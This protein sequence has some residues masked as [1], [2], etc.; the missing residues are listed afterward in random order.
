VSVSI[1]KGL[2]VKSERLVA[3]SLPRSGPFLA[4]E[5]DPAAT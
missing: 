1:L 3:F 4:T 5:L 2:V